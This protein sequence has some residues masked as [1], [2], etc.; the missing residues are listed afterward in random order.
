MSGKSS[1]LFFGIMRLIDMYNFY[2]YL[3]RIPDVRFSLFDLALLFLS[4]LH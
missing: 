4:D 1:H 2:T 3:L